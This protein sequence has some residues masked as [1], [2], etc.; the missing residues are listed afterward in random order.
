MKRY[1]K[2]TWMKL[3]SPEILQA[4]MRQ[5]DFSMSRLARYAGCS[6]S[7]IGHLCSGHKSSCTPALAGR[8]SEA[9]DVPTEALFDLRAS[10]ASGRFVSG[11]RIAS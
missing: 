8:I 11:E 2:G 6:K 4:F 7:M 1:P 10:A 9:L 3:R 5:K